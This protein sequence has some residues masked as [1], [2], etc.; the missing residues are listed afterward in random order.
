[1]LAVI[2]PP[3]IHQFN[4]VKCTF[5]APWGRRRMSRLPAKVISDRNQAAAAAVAITYIKV[6]ANMSKD[7]GVDIFKITVTY[8]ISLA[9][10]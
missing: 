8:V 7:T 5:S 10:S 2:V 9:A 4:R 1:M 3:N 6:A